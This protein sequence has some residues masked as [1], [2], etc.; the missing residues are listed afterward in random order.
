MILNFKG[1][2]LSAINQKTKQ[3]KKTKKKKKQVEEHVFILS[4]I[5]LLEIVMFFKNMTTCS[6]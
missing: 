3:K 6:L 1:M 2:F 4:L 5:P